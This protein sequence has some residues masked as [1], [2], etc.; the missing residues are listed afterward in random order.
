MSVD[1]DAV[2]YVGF[3]I[4]FEDF[5]SPLLQRTKEEFHMEDRFHPKTGKKLEKQEKVVDR[6]AGFDIVINEKHFEGP[7]SKDAL[8]GS[9]CPEDEVMEAIGELLNC[10]VSYTGDM[11]N[12]CCFYITFEPF[13]L[14]DKKEGPTLVKNIIKQAE[15]FERIRK[16]LKQ[17]IGFDPGPAEVG[18]L[19]SVC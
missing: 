2:S 7:E 19:M 1:H 5:F 10:Q 9:Y 6:P 11:Y 16:D 12:G 13:N 8:D 3:A 17:L 15:E 4:S 18:A 14:I